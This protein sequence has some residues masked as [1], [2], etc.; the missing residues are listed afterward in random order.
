MHSFYLF[1]ND[2][3]VANGTNYIFS[4]KVFAYSGISER[5]TIHF[6]TFA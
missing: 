3:A 4:A 1:K 6:L 2:P 5:A